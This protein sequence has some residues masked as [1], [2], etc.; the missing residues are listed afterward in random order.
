VTNLFLQLIS[1]LIKLCFVLIWNLFPIDYWLVPSMYTIY[2]W[3]THAQ[4]STQTSFSNDRAAYGRHNA[5]CSRIWAGSVVMDR[6]LLLRIRLTWFTFQI[7]LFLKINLPKM[8][9]WSFVLPIYFSRFTHIDMFLDEINRN[10]DLKIT[11][12]HI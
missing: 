9:I 12:S 5:I 4:P 10:L 3:T 2:Y 8:D 1:L 11:S 6:A 7:V